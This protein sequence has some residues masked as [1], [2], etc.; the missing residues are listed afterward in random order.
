MPQLA[1]DGNPQTALVCLVGVRVI[2]CLELPDDRLHLLFLLV[3]ELRDLVLCKDLL[4][5]RLGG[6]RHGLFAVGLPALVGLAV[7]QSGADGLQ[8]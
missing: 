2:V 7:C 5:P 4:H 3:G 6:G 1:A 8:T